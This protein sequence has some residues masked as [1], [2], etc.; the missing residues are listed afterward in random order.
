M[1]VQV[2]SLLDRGPGRV[3]SSAGANSFCH[4]RPSPGRTL[5]DSKAVAPKVGSNGPRVRHL[6]GHDRRE[7][8]AQAVAHEL[9]ELRPGDQQPTLRPG[10]RYA[11]GLDAAGLDPRADGV[12]CSPRHLGDLVDG[13]EGLVAPDQKIAHLADGREN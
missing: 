11:D 12:G 2:S 6:S 10:P 8:P 13:V 4:V 7:P 1:S 3:V 5:V 9:A